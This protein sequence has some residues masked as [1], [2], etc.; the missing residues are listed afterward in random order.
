MMLQVLWHLLHVR[1][2]VSV[3]GPRVQEIFTLCL[4]QRQQWP[5]VFKFLVTCIPGKIAEQLKR[6][7]VEQRASNRAGT[8]LPMAPV[9]AGVN[10]AD[11]MLL[12]VYQDKRD[13]AKQQALVKHTASMLPDA[14][15]RDLKMQADTR[16]AADFKAI[17]L[18]RLHH[19]S[20]KS[21]VNCQCCKSTCCAAYA[22]QSRSMHSK[23][24]QV[25]V[26]KRLKDQG[27][28]GNSLDT[29]DLI[30]AGK[31]AVVSCCIFIA[32]SV[33]VAN[34][35]SHTGLFRPSNRKSAC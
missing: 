33:W 4:Q 19:L 32:I 23:S 7:H 12:A 24:M 22:Y 34:G 21:T 26:S 3:I 15:Q 5:Q 2:G 35:V 29:R 27:R 18:V 25:N 13:C 28:L 9:W 30:P 17:L 16:D 11:K 8:A 31:F 10:K 14:L 6:L 1:P 20:C